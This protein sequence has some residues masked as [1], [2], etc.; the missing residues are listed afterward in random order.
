MTCKSAGSAGSTCFGSSLRCWLQ[1][2]LGDRFKGAFI[3][4]ARSP[5]F[6]WVARRVLSSVCRPH[7]LAGVDVGKSALRFDQRSVVESIPLL[8]IVIVC[9]LRSTLCLHRLAAARSV[10]PTR[11]TP[12][13]SCKLRRVRAETNLFSPQP[14]P[15]ALTSTVVRSARS[16][17]LGCLELARSALPDQHGD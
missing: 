5:S 3:L 2:G 12:T 17:R 13:G 9:A 6:A 16:V 1:V 7:F 4:L 15:V 14:E 11:H 10:A 8:L